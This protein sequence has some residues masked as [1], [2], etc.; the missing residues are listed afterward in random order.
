MRKTLA[1]LFLTLG[2]ATNVMAQDQIPSPT[3]VGG[4]DLS[5]FTVTTRIS[6]VNITLNGVE[7]I[8]DRR[9]GASRWPDN[10]TP[11]WSGPL[12]YSLGLCEQTDGVK[13]TCSAPIET[14]FGNNIIGGPIQS[15]DPPQ[16]AKNWFYD[17]RWGA[18]AGYQ[19]SP[20]DKLGIF[21]VAG[22]SR[23]SFNPVKERSNI[24]L[25]TLP[26]PDTTTSFNYGVTPPAPT[27]VPV[28][29]PSPTP[30]PGPITSGDY[31]AVLQEILAAEKALLVSQDQLLIVAKDTNSQVSEMNRTL[32]DT[33]KSISTFLA[34]YVAPA[35]SGWL[36]AKKIS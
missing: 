34:K 25:F 19:P 2:M 17:A 33:I 29:S 24:V 35:V 16:I 36:I 28:P 9:D 21:V 1:T 20:G 5:Q 8:F 11:G 31:T 7:V 4:P 26:A 27:P 14:W 32:G 13:W 15:Q 12:Q 6:R 10:T 3:F 22:D 18:L 30:N 23:N